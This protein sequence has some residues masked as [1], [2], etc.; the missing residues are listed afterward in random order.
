[1]TGFLRVL[2]WNWA[3]LVALSSCG[4]RVCICKYILSYLLL[5]INVIV[6]NVMVTIS[7]CL[8]TDYNVQREDN[9]KL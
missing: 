2:V 1:M 3:R 4:Q 5:P 6:V 7:N 9:Y 8:F